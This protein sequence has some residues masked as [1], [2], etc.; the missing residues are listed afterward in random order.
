MFKTKTFLLGLVVTI[1]LLLA[2]TGMRAEQKP[3]RLVWEY[4]TV[5]FRSSPISTPSDLDAMLNEQGLNGWELVSSEP[6]P[7]SG[8]P[9]HMKLFTFKRAR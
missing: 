4:K 3:S 5:E 2:A 8:V 1:A 6:D 9:N 7:R